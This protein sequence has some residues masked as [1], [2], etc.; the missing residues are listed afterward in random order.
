MVMLTPDGNFLDTYGKNHP[1]SPGEPR[2]ITAG[3]YPVYEVLSNP[4]ATLICN[5]VHYTDVSRILARRGARLIAVPTLEG[6]G[7]A[8]EQV[9]QSVMRAVENRVS[10]VKA[11]VAYASAIIDPYGKIIRLRNGAPDG[12]AFALVAEVPLGTKNTFYSRTCDILG[13]ICLGAFVFFIL[14]QQK[15]HKGHDRKNR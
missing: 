12:E 11:D 6:P 1:T 9:A 2:I 10:I 15:V 3:S 14:F 7:I 13:W 4:V 5:D 8:L